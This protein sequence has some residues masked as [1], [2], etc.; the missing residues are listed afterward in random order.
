MGDEIVWYEVGPRDGLQN[1]SKV[2]DPRDRVAMIERLVQAGV[3]HLEVGSFVHPKWVPQMA[4]TE[5]VVRG[6]PERRDVSYWALVPNLRGLER[7]LSVGVEHVAVV[8]S[9]TEAHNQKNLNRSLEQ[10]LRAME[11]TIGEAKGAGCSVRAYIST[12]F[13]CPFEGEVDFDVVMEIGEKLLAFGADHLSLGDTIGAGGPREIRAGCGRAVNEF[14]TGQVALHLHDTQGMALANALVA[15]EAG[16]RIF[17]GAVGGMGGCPY[18]PGA[19]GNVASE[20]LINL[21]EQMGADCGVDKDALAAVSSWLD[22]K[23][24]FSIGGRYYTYWRA[25]QAEQR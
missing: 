18:A 25:Q 2:V 12:A 13:G 9:A 19:A 3:R 4:G 21:L 15:Y 23:M 8:M 14:G 16:V 6:L 10:S 24:G 17:D 7:A 22:E 5:E 11:E 1:E 20:D